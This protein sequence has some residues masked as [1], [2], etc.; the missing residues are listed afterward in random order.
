MYGPP[1]NG[2]PARTAVVVPQVRVT[3]D[4]DD[5]LTIETSSLDTGAKLDPLSFVID[6]NGEIWIGN[7]DIGDVRR[8][9]QNLILSRGNF[10]TVRAFFAHLVG[11]IEP[12]VAG[13]ATESCDVD[14]AGFY[15][16]TEGRGGVVLP[17]ETDLDRG[18]RNCYT[19]T[20][21]K[22]GGK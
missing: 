9:I 11:R 20:V 14:F 16:L 18:E 10:K 8:S 12:D 13:A 7:L 17:C 3:V 1:G 5:R 22:P 2:Q 19:T 15:D 6:R 4:V 21:S